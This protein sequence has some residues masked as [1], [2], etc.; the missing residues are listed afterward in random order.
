M[1]MKQFII[2]IFFSFLPAYMFAQNT[3]LPEYT[4]DNFSQE[5]AM[6]LFKNHRTQ[7]RRSVYDPDSNG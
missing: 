6:A 2:Y 7:R 5:G 3:D 4:G 1:Y